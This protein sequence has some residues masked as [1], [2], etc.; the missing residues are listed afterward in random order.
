MLERTPS[1][2]ELETLVGQLRDENRR[3][4]ERVE[5]LQAEL[6]EARQAAAR[7]AAP[8]RRRE[9][10][11]KPDAE[12]KRPGRAPG[13]EGHYRQM[14][15]QIDETIEAPL[16]GCP[17]C[18][19]ELSDVRPCVQVIEELPPVTPRRIKLTTW[20]GHCAQC[21]EVRSAHPLQTSTAVGAAGTH[22]GPRAQALA[23]TL[24]HQLGLTMSRTC[25]ALRVMSGLKLTPGGLSQL[26]ARVGRRL[27]PWYA[28]IRRQIRESA[29]VFG[30]ETSWYV[31]RPWWLWVFTTPAATLY[32]VEPGRGADVVLDTLG[33]DFRGVLVSDCLASYNPI[34]C[35]KHKCIAH[36]L[37]V[38]KERAAVLER[39]GIFSRYLLCWKIQLQ[40][41]IETWKQRDA[42]SP[43]EYAEKV[44]QLQRG[45]DNLL[46]EAPAEPEEEA[47]GNRLRRVRAH[48]LGCLADPAAEPTNN[49]AE[50]DLRPAVISRK[51]SCGNRTHAGKTTWETLRS[52]VVTAQKQGRDLLEELPRRL[53]LAIPPP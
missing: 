34:E 27:E 28:E 3:F 49:R 25:E 20:C 33:E 32:R 38:L 12:K 45:V 48:L 46:D 43:A 16:P 47:F 2:E 31:T 7:Q 29:A 51:L 15:E 14:P 9:A 4:A 10:L 50:R 44:A 36:H 11:K 5:A 18:H 40:D 26:L 1:Y 37:R 35:R 24:N 42:R 8:F 39:R 23:V 17:H 21:G 30:D 41:V 22:L 19:G 13:H 52:I 6:A 53:T